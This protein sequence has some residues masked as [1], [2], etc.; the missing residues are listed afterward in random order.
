MYCARNRIASFQRDLARS[1]PNL[2]TLV[3]TENVVA[4]LGDLEPLAQF[5]KLTHLSLL[6]NPVSGKDNYRYYLI[7][8][9]PSLRFLDFARIRDAERNTARELFGTRE[10]PTDLA[11][12]MASQ[13]A[14]KTGVVVNGS[15]TGPVKTGSRMRMTD[16]EK[17]RVRALIKNAGSLAEIARLEKM[18]A[19]GR[20]PGGLGDGMD[21]R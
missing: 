2:H 6:D 7:Y 8:L 19:E 21:G 12:T 10:E 17:E 5:A 9:L 4:D 3:L 13:K 20:I 14:N 1:I 11:R 18:L 16:E 15:G